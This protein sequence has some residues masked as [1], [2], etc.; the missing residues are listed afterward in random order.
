[1]HYTTAIILTH[2]LLLMYD[3]MADSAI[4]ELNLSLE[5]VVLWYSPGHHTPPNRYWQVGQLRQAN[6]AI[7]K[8]IIHRSAGGAFRRKVR[9]LFL[10]TKQSIAKLR[11]AITIVIH[12]RSAGAFR[13]KVLFL[14]RKKAIAKPRQAIVEGG[15]EFWEQEIVNNCHLPRSTGGPPVLSAEKCCFCPQNN[16]LPR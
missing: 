5:L 7:I 2:Y 11:Q 16:Q 15:R 6:L 13:R 8:F 12:R 4:S 14:S 1:M 9:V 10:S 3:D